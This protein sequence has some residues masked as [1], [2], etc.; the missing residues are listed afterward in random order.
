[1]H[2][3]MGKFLSHVC[4]ISSRFIT[5]QFYLTID[6]QFRNYTVTSV[7]ASTRTS[8]FLAWRVVISKVTSENPRITGYVQL[9]EY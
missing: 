1:M 9:F 4:L 7:L 6:V 5:V 2:M 8:L 3:K